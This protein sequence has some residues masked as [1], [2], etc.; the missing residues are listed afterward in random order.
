MSKHNRSSEELDT[1]MAR[2]KVVYEKHPD[3]VGILEYLRH[4]NDRL[5]YE[6]E[7]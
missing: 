6:A 4:T 7:L 3:D 1:R 5:D 2:A